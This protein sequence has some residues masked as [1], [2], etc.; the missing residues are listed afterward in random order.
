ML[1]EIWV[2]FAE[3]GGGG[4]LGIL[5][6]GSFRVFGSWAGWRYGKLGSF[7]IM[8]MVGGK[9]EIRKLRGLGFRVE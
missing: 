1:G 6:L 4:T 2:R 3:I 5:E 8:G 7:R 9:S